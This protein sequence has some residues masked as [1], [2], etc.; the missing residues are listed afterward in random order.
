MSYMNLSEAAHAITDYIVGCYTSLRPHEYN[1]GL[2]PNESEN[3]CW[4]TS[5]VVANFCRPLHM[6]GTPLGPLSLINYPSPSTKIFLEGLSKPRL[7]AK[8]D[9]Q[10][11]AVLALA[12]KILAEF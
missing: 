1:S 6:Q 10:S 9:Q 8:T 7:I 5:K 12:E 2:P 3:R 4:K 11:T